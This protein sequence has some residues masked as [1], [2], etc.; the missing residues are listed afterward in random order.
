MSLPRLL[1]V[2]EA[3]FALTVSPA[4]VYEHQREL[5]AVKIGRAVRIPE[6]GIEGYLQQHVTLAEKSRRRYIS[7]A[8]IRRND[9]ALMRIV[10]GGRTA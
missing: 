7:R 5:G 10:R 6:P 8:E 1:T 3:A 2:P 9:S 4:W